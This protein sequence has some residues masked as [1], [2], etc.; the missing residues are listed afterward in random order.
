MGRAQ[1][2]GLL[3]AAAVFWGSGNVAQKTVLEDIGPFTAIGIRCLIAAIVLAPFFARFDARPSQGKA[4]CTVI[5]VATFAVAITLYQFASGLTTVTNTGFLVNSSTV[6]TPII[7]WLMLRHRPGVLVWPAAAL[8]L[9]GVYLMGGGAFTQLN[10]GDAFALAAALFY[11]V[12]MISL[13][14]YVMRYGQAGTITLVQF[15]FT[16]L[17]C[18]AI[19]LMV[20][21]ISL[22]RLQSALPELLFLGIASTGIGYLF[23]AI[24]QA[25]TSASE[26]AVIVSGEAIFGALCAFALLGE[27]LDAR[28]ILGATLILAGIGVVQLNQFVQPN[29][30]RIEGEK[31]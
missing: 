16:G 11:S 29:S 22:V 21:P 12:W 26:A 10:L 17:A 14:H 23:Q 28:G 27:S 30:L 7:A 8:T 25:H 4:K 31:S 2:N 18:L 24:A 15:V 13:G 1:A 20:E 19:G 6:L 9:L 3:L 5:V